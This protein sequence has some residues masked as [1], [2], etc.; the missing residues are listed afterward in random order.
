MTIAVIGA[1]ASGMMAALQAAW[2]GGAVTLFERN[3]SVGRKLLVT[4]SGRC[5]IT[6]EAA[7][8]A[9]YTCADPRW[10][11]TLLSRFGVADLLAVLSE[12]GIPVHKTS[13]GWYYPLSDS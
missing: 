5:N 13:D 6:N 12:I 8:A 7:A 9:A 11:E 1:G 2:N 4:G 10:M 3:T